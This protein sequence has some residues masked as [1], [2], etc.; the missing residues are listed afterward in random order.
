[1]AMETLGDRI[2]AAM[3]KKKIKSLRQLANVAEIPY[4]TLYNY[5]NDKV[6]KLDIL[7]IKKLAVAL[8]VDY[9]YLTSDNLLK[10]PVVVYGTQL[11]EYESDNTLRLTSSVKRLELEV[12]ELRSIQF[13][14]LNERK[15]FQDHINTLQ[16]YNSVLEGKLGIARQ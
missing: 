13:G 12:Q 3:N 7:I 15:N 2:K 4:T 8:E 16:R 9:D 5:A 14:L 11:S 6:E 10:E 1:M